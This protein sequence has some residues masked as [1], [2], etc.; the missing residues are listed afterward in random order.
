MGSIAT[1]M[2]SSL[3]CNTF[4]RIHLL[5]EECVKLSLAQLKLQ[6]VVDAHPVV[7]H[8]GLREIRGELRRVRACSRQVLSL[9]GMWRHRRDLRRPAG[10]ISR[11]APKLPPRYY[12]QGAETRLQVEFAEGTRRIARDYLQDSR[13]SKI[14]PQINLNFQRRTFS[15][16]LN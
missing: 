13:R 2:A 8:D 16:N 12:F 14:P 15:L 1:D 4:I 5:S 7:V 6:S 3:P 10:R 11:F 9:C